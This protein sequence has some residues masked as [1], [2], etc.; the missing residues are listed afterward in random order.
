MNGLTCYVHCL[1]R[2]SLTTILLVGSQALGTPNLASSPDF[3]Y[4]D[5][6]RLR[7]GSDFKK[8]LAEILQ[9]YHISQP[10]GPD[11]IVRSC[12]TDIDINCYSHR[13]LSY[14]E[15]RQ[16]LFGHLYLQGLNELEFSVPAVYCADVVTNDELPKNQALGPMKIPDHSVVNAEHAW[17]QSR[18]SKKSPVSLQKGDLLALYPVRMRVNS[19]RRAF[20]FGEVE[21]AANMPCDEAA[22]G[23]N[24]RGQTVFE[25]AE[26][27]KG[28]VAR[29]LFYFA[30]R[31][32]LS[33]D[34]EEE[35]TL[36]QWHEMDP[37]DHKESAKH[38]ETFHIQFIRNPFIDHPEWVDR[39]NDF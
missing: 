33:I 9:S 28:N 8:R 35:E 25:P 39:V 21:E 13:E 29:S 20:P 34:Q 37:V 1:F 11:R 18:F 26:N 14:R 24:R 12:S 5:Q 32:G 19:T 4:G 31:Y 6:A 7:N 17:P 38:E 15:A 22:L 30:V 23:S 36:R 2:V 3:Y 27:I 16:F 10:N